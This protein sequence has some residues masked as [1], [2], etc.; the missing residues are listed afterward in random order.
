L[1]TNYQS[2]LLPGAQETKRLAVSRSVE[3]PAMSLFTWL[4]WK[5]PAPC[6][7]P[8]NLA[9]PQFKANPFPFYA[10]LR[11]EAPV[12]RMT[13]PTRETAWL[14][15]RCDDVATVFKD[16]RFV[17]DASNAL[18]SA[19]IARLPWFRKLFKSLER[20]LL[21]VDPPDHP[22]L[23]GLVQ[24]A[25]TPRLIE[26]MR[27]RVQQ[28]AEELLDRA[29]DRGHMDLIGDYALP[30]PTT[31]IAE[32]LGVPTEDRHRFHRWSTALISA[33]ASPWALLRAVPSVWAMQRYLKRIITERR[34]RPRDDLVSALVRVEQAGEILSE[35][36]LMAMVFLLLVA[37]HETTVNLIGNGML[38][39]MEHPDQLDRLR[40]QPALIKP[41]VEE[42]L[43]YASPVDLATERYAREDIL[44][45]GV[46]IPR[47]EMVFAVVTS[48]NRDERAFPNPDVLDITRDPNRHLAFG[49][50]AHFCLGASLARL[51]GQIAISTLLRRVPDVG[52]ATPASR[53]RWRGGL[54]LRGLESL[55][56]AFARPP[57]G[58][59]DPMEAKL[60]PTGMAD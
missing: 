60:S 1:Q 26:Q 9:S 52:L 37:G 51:E 41:A 48:A 11:A 55:P 21:N 49:L 53:L 8:V 38:A 57:A 47:G 58:K 56:V 45:A 18:T 33:A 14:V 2:V 54:L 40:K 17:K 39:L 34:N 5:A 27:P 30:I 43:R 35:G 16:E 10:R 20:N 50:G 12:L 19:Q 7:A 32:L 59:R 22:R 6:D 28:L 23:R 29:T 15:T 24:Q 46:T 44:L 36:E 3:Y 42:L 13:L 4:T 25:F 31:I